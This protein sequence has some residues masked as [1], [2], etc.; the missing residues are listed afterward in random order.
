MDHTNRLG[1]LL[2]LCCNWFWTVPEPECRRKSQ[3]GAC[4]KDCCKFKGS[5]ELVPGSVVPRATSAKLHLHIFHFLQQF[6][7]I[8]TVLLFWEVELPFWWLGFVSLLFG[9]FK[10]M[11]NASNTFSMALLSKELE[12]HSPRTVSWIFLTV[13]CN[14]VAELPWKP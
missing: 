13:K 6:Q 3:V 10:H 1:F 9:R 8:S 14:C 12:L 2:A 7:V 5:A 4:T 11:W